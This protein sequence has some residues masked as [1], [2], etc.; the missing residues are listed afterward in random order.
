M[1]PRRTAKGLLL[2]VSSPS[3]AGKTTLAR[4]LMAEFPDRI[5]FSVSYTTRPPRERETPGVDYHFVDGPTF[6]RMV[7]EDRF[8]EWAQV[9]GHRYG[10]ARS[11][12]EEAFAE[13][14]DVLFDIDYQ[15]GR[16]LKARYPAE[17]VRVFVLPP[18]M[19]TLAR[20]LRGRATD[21]PEVIARRLAKAVD[22]LG[23]YHAYEYLLVN[24]DLDR[25]YDEL[26]AIY[27][28]SLCRWDRQSGYAEQL[29]AEASSE[30]FL[31]DAHD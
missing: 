23:H 28:A 24:D 26:R 1:T 12:I 8:A 15:G 17:S 21:A 4:R 22:E 30:E 9:H 25:A 13:G 11:A 29:L 7:S 10:T 18:D 3:G 20:R 31:R 14:K 27:L 6:E 5:T 2:V 19:R 16:Q